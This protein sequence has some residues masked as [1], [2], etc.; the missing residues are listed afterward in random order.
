MVA[1]PADTPVTMPVLPTV[2]ILLDAG[3]HVPPAAPVGSASDV[4][5][6]AHTMGVPVMA[7]ALG[8]GFT[9]TVFVVAQFVGSV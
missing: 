6:A 9:V 5:A 7:P 3:L 1:V 8:K 2:A 4:V